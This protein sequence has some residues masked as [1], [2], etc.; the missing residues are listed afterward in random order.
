MLPI[1][2]L[3]QSGSLPHIATHCHTGAAASGVGGNECSG[4]VAKLVQGVQKNEE[5]L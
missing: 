4:S 1:R 5:C 2:S 3:G